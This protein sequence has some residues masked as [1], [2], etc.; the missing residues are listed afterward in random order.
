MIER[1]REKWE[2]TMTDRERFNRQMHYRP[3]DRCFNMEMGWWE[4]NYTNW[5]MFRENGITNREEAK[6][7]CGLDQYA[8]IAQW[9]KVWMWPRFEEKVI[10]DRGRT[11]IMQNWEGLLAEVPKDGHSTIAHFIHSPVET[12]EDWEQMKREHFQVDHPGRTVDIAALKEK[13]PDD[14]DWPLGIFVGSMIG[15][16]RDLLTVNGLAY[17]CVDYPEMVEDMVETCCQLSEYY[18]DQVLPH[19]H[20]D[21][22]LTWE[23]ICCNNVPLVSL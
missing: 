19:F 16:V 9:D 6:R 2:G 1:M 21:Y 3:V 12:P 18:M 11:L 8:Y 14:R 4:E 22:A 10:E 5:P 13:Y 23:D 20:F 15:K 7:F 17:A